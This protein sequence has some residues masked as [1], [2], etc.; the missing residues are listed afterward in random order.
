MT[1]PTSA[2]AARRREVL[3]Q[4]LPPG[5]QRTPGI[6]L[7]ILADFSVVAL[8]GLSMWLVVRAGEQP[9]ILH[10]TFAIV[11]VRAFAIGRAAFRYAERLAS[12]DAALHQLSEL[13][14]QTFAR[15]IP[16][17]PGALE[18][19]RRGDVLSAFVDDV[20]QLQDEPL[21][22][23]QPL[24]VT[25]VVVLLSVGLV[26]LASWK[27]ALL[28]CASLVVCGVLGAVFAQRLG[29]HSDR[30]LS[31]A[32]SALTDA[33]LDRFASANVLTA[34]GALPDQRARIVAAEAHLSRV[35]ERRA[36]S[37]GVSGGL[38]TLGA[39]LTTLAAFWIAEPAIGQELTAPLFAAIVIVPAA[40][41]EVFAQVFAA[42]AARRAV[43]VSA[44]RVAALTLTDLPPE[45]PVDPEA[46]ASLPAQ[47]QLGSTPLIAFTNLSATYPHHHQPAFTGLSGELHPGELLI[48]TGPSG[49][50][51]STLALVLTRL[52]DY[53]GSYELYGVP[54]RSLSGETIRAQVGLCEQSPHLFDADLRQNLKFARESASDAELLAVLDRVGLSEWALARGGLDARV[55]EQGSLVSGGQAQRI[56]LARTILADTPVVILDEPTA[57]VDR[58]RAD[59][60]LRDLLEAIPDDRAVVLIT[61]TEVPPEVQGRHLKLGETA[62]RG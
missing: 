17:V 37:A 7:G 13:R 62:T 60:L 57:G 29:G 12:H 30:E 42:L 59:R 52:L 38:V 24:L 10:L 33:L 28:L 2:Q 44:D 56:A 32:R 25:L 11:G 19:T 1:S 39:G 20:D 51:K 22:V 27:V 48:V 9:P 8:L 58:E 21:R 53:T 3:R 31:A 46:S 4:A 26:A 6:L 47:Q 36:R 18:S 16:R 41:Y 49:A 35:Q 23:R 45:I 43:T 50:G 5:A 15:L 40:V 34:F 55:G 61:H 14:S 54:A